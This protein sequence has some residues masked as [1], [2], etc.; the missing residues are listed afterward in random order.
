M[1]SFLDYFSNDNPICPYCDNKIKDWH[2][3][4]SYQDDGQTDLTCDKCEKD[5]TCTTLIKH[6]FSTE[7][8]CKVHKLWRYPGNKYSY[9]CQVCAFECYDF[10]LEGG[11]HQNLN[12]DQ[13]EI[14]NSDEEEAVI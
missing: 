11:A 8:D 2:E 1:K 13:Y 14:I 5:F 10:H 12:K 6:T 7:G 4:V 9:T 3:D